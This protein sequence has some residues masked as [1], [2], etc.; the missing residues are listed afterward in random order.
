M[1]VSILGCKQQK[2]A[3]CHR[4]RRFTGRVSGASRSVRWMENKALK[5]VGTRGAQR[6]R[7]AVVSLLEMLRRSICSFV[8]LTN[9]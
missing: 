1:S 3:H 4:E 8:A 6:V 9:W 2:L 7:W 5:K